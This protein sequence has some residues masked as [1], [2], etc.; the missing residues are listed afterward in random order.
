MTINPTAVLDMGDNQYEDGTLAQ[1]QAVYDPS[2]GQFKAKTYPAPGNHEYHVS[3]APGYFAY[4]TGLQQYYSFDIGAWHL[5]SVNSELSLSNGSTEEQWL[6]A[7]LAAHP[8]TC[9]LAYWHEPRWS[10]G[11][12]H[13]SDSRS[14][15]LWTDLYNAGADVVLNGHEHVYERFAPQNPSGQ[16]DPTRGIT[17]FVAGTGGSMLYPFGTPLPNSVFRYN[18]GFGVLKLTLHPT[19]FDFAFVGETGS[20]IDSGTQQ[21]H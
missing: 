11:S 9:T 13:G 19:S 2:W 12:Q 20:V 4:F 21:C 7:D 14:A 8:N 15:T 17:E 16:S 10:S 6:K 3:G 5:I 1:Y 18:S